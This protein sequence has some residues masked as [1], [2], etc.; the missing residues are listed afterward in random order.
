[1]VQRVARFGL[2]GLVATAAYYIASLSA[3]VVVGVFWA[4][5]VGF[6]VAVF[7]SYYGHHRITFAAAR[8]TA[9]H[10]QAIARFAVSTAIAFAASQAA[11]YVGVELLQLP[12][13]AGLA[14]VVLIVPMFSFLLFQFWVFVPRSR[15]RKAASSGA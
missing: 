9:D 6:G 14:L 12:D 3:S 7:V 4:N 11:L 13:W 5:L 15:E 1:M 8:T 10:R 2:V